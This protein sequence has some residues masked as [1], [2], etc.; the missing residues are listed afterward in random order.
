VLA[1]RAPREAAAGLADA[2]RRSLRELDPTVP[3]YDVATTRELVERSAASRRFVM[4]LLAAFAGAALLL[5]ALG[6]YGVVAHAV[7]QRT[8]EIGIRMALGATPRDIRRLVLSS[9]TAVVAAGLAAGVATALAVMRLLSSL[10]Y[11][12]SPRDPLALSAA[13]V[14]LGAVALAAH[15]I[16]ARRAARVAPLEALREE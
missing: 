12:V 3:I 13:A 5:A 7:G 1:V 9:G 10:L 11:E 16:P 2:V 8:R 4:R 15:W 6:I 14:A